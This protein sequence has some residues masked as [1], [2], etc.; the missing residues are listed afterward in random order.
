MQCWFAMI[1]KGKAQRFKCPTPSSLT[2]HMCTCMML[3]QETQYSLDVGWLLSEVAILPLS[4]P[5]NELPPRRFW[6]FSFCC[7]PV[8]GNEVVLGCIFGGLNW[9][10]NIQAIEQHLNF[11]DMTWHQKRCK[12]SNGNDD[13]K[14]NLCDGHA[15]S[16]NGK[17]WM[18]RMIWNT[19]SAVTLI[20]T[21]S[22]NLPQLS[23]VQFEL[24][25]GL[26]KIDKLSCGPSKNNLSTSANKHLKE[27]AIFFGFQFIYNN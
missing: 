25:V 19:H 16:V 22:P 27:L 8:T 24:M 6:K 23:R 4:L 18:E 7:L 10:Q 26:V 15:I 5:A 17:R 12:P 13:W 1:I 3:W 11:Q 9:N 21:T 14:Q 20:S 2:H